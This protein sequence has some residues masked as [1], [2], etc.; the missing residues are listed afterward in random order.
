MA[1]ML[2]LRCCPFVL[3]SDPRP[4]LGPSP[5]LCEGFVKQLSGASKATLL[6]Y[7][8]L[9]YARDPAEAGSRVR[10][11]LGLDESG[12]LPV[13]LPLRH[14]RQAQSGARGCLRLVVAQ[15]RGRDPPRR[16]EGIAS[17]RGSEPT[18]CRAYRGGIAL[19]RR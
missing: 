10:E 9:P 18:A 4:P 13:V 8:A 5:G 14:G 7:L 16:A 2:A 1:D 19:M 15:R 12:R 6:C 3:L 17:P 11:K